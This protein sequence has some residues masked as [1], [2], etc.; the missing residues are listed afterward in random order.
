MTNFSFGSLATTSAQPTGGQYMRAYTIN[1]NVKLA[2]IEGP[3]KGTKDGNEWTAYDFIFA[4]ENGATYKER[5]FAPKDDTYFERRA[6]PS[7]KGFGA[8]NFDVLNVF[9]AHVVGTLNPAGFEKLQAIAGKITSFDGMMEAVKK[10]MMGC[11]TTT[12]LKLC[13]R[14]SNGTVYAAL[15]NFVS[16]LEDEKVPAKVGHAF[17]G[18]NVAFTKYEETKKAEYESATPTKM[19]TASEDIVTPKEDSTDLDALM[20]GL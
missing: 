2:S 17:L 8:S 15:P 16:F 10:I 12:K 4:N 7:G 14:N 13:G 19:N 1:D 9:I 5:F 3:I 18:D 11:E 20:A 6:F